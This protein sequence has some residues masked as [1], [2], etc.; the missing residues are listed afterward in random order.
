MYGSDLQVLHGV[1]VVLHEDDGV[2]PGEV[3]A[4]AAHAGAQQ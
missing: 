2:R 1:P 4:E 3:E